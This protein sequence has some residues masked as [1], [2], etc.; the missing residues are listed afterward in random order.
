MAHERV[1]RALDEVEAARAALVEA[2][3]VSLWASLYPSET[4][5]REPAWGALAGGLR[6]LAR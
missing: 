6:A 5:G 2:R 4:A 1:E 3:R